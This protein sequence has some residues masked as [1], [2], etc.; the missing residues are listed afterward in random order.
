[1]PI[2]PVSGVTSTPVSA[3]IK[4]PASAV[5][6]VS[7]ADF[8]AKVL[9]AQGPVVV[10]FMNPACPHCRRMEPVLQEVAQKLVGKVQVFQVNIMLDGPLTTHLGVNSVPTFLMFHGGKE[11]GRAQVGPVV[12]ELQKAISDAFKPS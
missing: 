11:I 9:R 7:A 10:Q 12:A 6:P 2:T 5:I 3:P 1:M 8:V 4:A